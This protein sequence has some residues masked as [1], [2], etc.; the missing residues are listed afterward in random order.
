MS[1]TI[2]FQSLRDAAKVAMNRS[3]APYSRFPVGAAGITR[4]GRIVVGSNVE[5]V[6]YGL[7]LCA[8]VSMVCSAVSLGHLSGPSDGEPADLIAVSV[9]DLHGSPLTP[10]GRCRQVLLEFGGDDLLVDSAT[11]PRALRSLL[12]DAF[13]PGHL[14]GRR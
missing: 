2:D 12:P 5:N 11:G 8:E 6:S 10:C 13:G 9:C 14:A 7:G 4:A 1:A 3:Y